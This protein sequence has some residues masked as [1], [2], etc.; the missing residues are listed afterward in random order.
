MGQEIPGHE[1]DVRNLGAHRIEERP[2][3]FLVSVQIGNQKTPGT[4]QVVMKRLSDL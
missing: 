4:V 3:S 1:D 2:V